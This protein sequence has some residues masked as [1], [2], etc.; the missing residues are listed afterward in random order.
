MWQNDDIRESSTH[1]SDNLEK[2]SQRK[3]ATSLLQ[4][5]ARYSERASPLSLALILLTLSEDLKV[6][7]PPL[8]G[9]PLSELPILIFFQA[10]ETF[11][12]WWEEPKEKR[13]R[14][15]RQKNGGNQIFCRVVWSQGTSWVFPRAQSVRTHKIKLKID[16]FFSLFSQLLLFFFKLL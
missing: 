5:E 16:S 1:F 13:S 8:K 2:I 15:P 4:M 11:P 12:G 9:S 3:R 10:T 14:C 7:S 6:P